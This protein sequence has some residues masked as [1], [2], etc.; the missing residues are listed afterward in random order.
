M[1]LDVVI[2]DKESVKEITA[3]IMEK[4]E[5]DLMQGCSKTSAWMVAL[6]QLPMTLSARVPSSFPSELLL[7]T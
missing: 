3:A 1:A 6:Y 2:K 7:N 5:G 4:G